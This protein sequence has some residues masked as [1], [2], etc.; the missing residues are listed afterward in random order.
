MRFTNKHNLPQAM[1]DIIDNDYD[2]SKAD[3]KRIS[4]TTLINPPIQRLLKVRHWEEIEED[5]SDYI[6]LITGSAYHYILSKIEDN[7]EKSKHRLIE[8]K[9]EVKVDDITIVGK[10]DLF[11]NVL[12]S[13][14]DYKI[15]SVWSVKFGDHEDWEKQCNCY[16]WL[17]RKCGFEVNKL[18]INAILRDWR[19]SERLKYD[20]Y[21]NIPFKR[22]E[23]KLWSF[24]QQQAYVESRVKLYKDQSDLPTEKLPI[25]SDSERWKKEDSY[26]VYKGTNKTASRVLEDA[27]KA[28]DWILSN[29]K[30]GETYKVVKRPGIDLKCTEYCTV[31]TFCSYY[32]E[33]YERNSSKETSQ[34]S[35]QG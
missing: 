12:K 28:E 3:P 7:K 21:P 9:I 20:D 29:Q 6:W 35:L 27:M 26:A 13:V 33:N 15:T 2:L 14:E 24:E 18:Y 32:K 5:V 11:D 1:V 23:V 22:I 4:I 8:E 10:L 19:K 16:A 34:D 17:L 30:K 31:C 25:C